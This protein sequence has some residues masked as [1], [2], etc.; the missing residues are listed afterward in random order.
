M[1]SPKCGDSRPAH[2]FEKIFSEQW[3]RTLLVLYVALNLVTVAVLTTPRWAFGAASESYA[4]E[5]DAVLYTGGE[6]PE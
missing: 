2:H 5:P 6:F 4:T 1:Q 3:L